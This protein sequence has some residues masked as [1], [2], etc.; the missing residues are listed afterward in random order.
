MS[1]FRGLSGRL[2]VLTIL[3]VMLVEVAIFVPSVSRFRIA[4][5][6][7]R[8]ERAHIASLA[9]L[10]APDEMVDEH[11]EAELLAGAEVLNVVMYREGS[12]ALMLSRDQIPEVAAAFDLRAMSAGPLIRDAL[13]RLADP[14]PEVIRV[15]GV[16][17]GGANLLEIT[18]ETAPLR[19]AMIDYGWRI[20]KLSLAISVLTGLAVFLVICLLV[21]VPLMRLTENLRAFQE[22]PDDPARVIRPRRGSGELA[23][24]ERAVAEMQQTVQKAFE[25]RRRLASL[26]E[27]VAKISH[28]LRNMLASLQLTVD[29]L[30]TSKDP[31]VSRVM[32]KVMASLDRALTLCKRTLAYGKAEETAPEPRQIR[33]RAL[34]EEVAEG[35]GLG[36]D[37]EPVR[38]VVAVP[39]HH[40]VTADPDQLYRVLLNLVRN[41]TEAIQQTNRPG[42][43]R[44]TAR[45]EGGSDVIAVADTGPGL[46]ARAAENLFQPF[47]GSARQGGTGLGLAIAGELVAAHGGRLTLAA[48]GP[49]GTVF[50]IRLPAESGTIRLS[51]KGAA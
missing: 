49:D 38:A 20:L 3:V 14:T 42:E 28:D 44:I 48:S 33:L 36:P 11:L 24:T 45:R 1:V 22:K 26:G 16:P 10:A 34:A 8:I 13:A 43:V 2:L 7:E 40:I 17:R 27:A 9:V 23:Q 41:A 51:A 4:Y 37:A 15:K 12:R 46:P 29:R 19:A 35:L 47:R 32:P 5:L 31:L 25:E 50:E 30:E 18:I 39:D 6:E 21:V